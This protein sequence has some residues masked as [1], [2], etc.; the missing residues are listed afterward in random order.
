MHVVC[1]IPLTA[2][3]SFLLPLTYFVDVQ[4]LEASVLTDTEA[5]LPSVKEHTNSKDCSQHA[6]L[7]YRVFR[8]IVEV[9]IRTTVNA[10]S[11]IELQRHKMIVFLYINIFS[12]KYQ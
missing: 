7:F 6:S 5:T 2:G 11:Y 10:C 12:E 1:G 3:D 8:F 9:I 4:E